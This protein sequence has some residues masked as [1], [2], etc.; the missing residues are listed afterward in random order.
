MKRMAG[1]GVYNPNGKAFETT[2][3]RIPIAVSLL[4]SFTIRRGVVR[5]VK[6]KQKTGGCFPMSCE[7][8]K[9]A[10]VLRRTEFSTLFADGK[11]DNDGRRTPH[12]K[13]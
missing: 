9:L 1:L 3:A 12:A 4:H 13:V 10:A 11:L 7:F 5:R 2:A 8:L 6:K